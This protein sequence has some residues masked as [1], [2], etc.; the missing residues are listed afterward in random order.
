MNGLSNAGFMGGLMQG[1]QFAEGMQNRAHARGLA[2]EAFAMKKETHGQ[3]KELNDQAIAKGKESALLSSLD[4][5]L[6]A[7]SET[8]N[9]LTAEQWNKYQ[10]LG[11][12]QL[13]DADWRERNQNA[14]AW[15]H[16]TI[17]TGEWNENSLDAI[18]VAFESDLKKR[19]MKDGLKRRVVGIKDAGNDR[20][21]A[22]MEITRKDGSK[23]RAPITKAGSSDEEDSLV[24]FDD[25]KLDEIY[26]V[27]MHRA[28]IAYAVEKAGGDPKKLAQVMRKI[29]FKAEAKKPA[30]VISKFD[31]VTGLEQRMF[32]DQE[33]G[34][35]TKFG[36]NKARTGKGA[37]SGR[38]KGSNSG[39]VDWEEYRKLKSD[40]LKTGDPD[41]IQGVDDMFESTRGFTVDDFIK[42]RKQFEAR[43]IYDDPTIEQVRASI[44]GANQAHTET[45]I[46]N[47]IAGNPDEFGSTSNSGLQTNQYGQRVVTTPE[48]QQDEINNFAQVSGDSPTSLA[49][50]I[51]QN[52]SKA[53]DT[54]TLAPEGG[55]SELTQ[56]VSSGA[57]GFRGMPNFTQDQLNNI[58]AID[59][60]KSQIKEQLMSEL[61]GI[62]SKQKRSGRR[63]PSKREASLM[64]ALRDV[65]N[66]YDVDSINSIVAKIK[67]D[68]ESKKPGIKDPAH[69]AAL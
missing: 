63:T 35:L 24:L 8:G 46:N 53:E 54:Q 45:R 21:A 48:D 61:Q 29:A 22:I 33:T 27:Q 67:L 12:G 50:N 58:A 64:A 47:A 16:R 20:M 49:E 4:R 42:V 9:P 26:K 15:L 5:D 65:D 60:T 41:A 14:G 52:N 31:E 51:A 37:G 39:G 55:L 44:N 69:M 18:N 2:D 28:D 11:F 66:S 56:N 6:R 57:A 68:D 38:S 23:Y 7:M 17:T 1:A 62:R 36:G 13:N 43:G 32:Q 3:Q 10:P 59:E 40:A 19:E 30:K 34:A 25:K